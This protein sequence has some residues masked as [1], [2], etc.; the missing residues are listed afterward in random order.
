MRAYQLVLQFPG[1]SL[2]DFDALVALEDALIDELPKIAKVDGHDF[3]S[4][5]MNIF[6]HTDHP[7]ETFETVKPLL[8]KR[9]LLI[10]VRAAYRA[11]PDDKYTIL[12][13]T[14]LDKPF[15]IK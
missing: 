3:G 7:K 15:N 8:A 13:P 12:W 1:N 4:G 6:I 2:G 5:E 10:L 9:D 14:N 11:I